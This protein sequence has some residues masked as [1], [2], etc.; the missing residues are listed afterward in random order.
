[1]RVL[2]VHQEICGT[3]SYSDIPAKNVID[4]ITFWLLYIVG[5]NMT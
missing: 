1:M 5:N 3:F 4:A 2:E